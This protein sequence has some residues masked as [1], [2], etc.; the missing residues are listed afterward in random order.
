MR[1]RGII[2]DAMGRTPGECH[3]ESTVLGLG[4]DDLEACIILSRVE[5]CFDIILGSD[6]E[7]VFMQGTVGAFIDSVEGQ[8]RAAG[9]IS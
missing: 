9:C 5:F 7:K 8:V 1:V 4:T 2:A 6:A 3:E